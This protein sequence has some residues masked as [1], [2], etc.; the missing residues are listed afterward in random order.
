MHPVSNPALHAVP[1]LFKQPLL[2]MQGT[3]HLLCLVAVVTE[4]VKA[5]QQ[6]AC[7]PEASNSI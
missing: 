5:S 4:A 6:H 7:L 2:S 3:L 1:P